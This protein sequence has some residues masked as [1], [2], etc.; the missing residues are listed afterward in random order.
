MQEPL[1]SLLGRTAE[2]SFAKEIS[3][4]TA[5]IPPEVDQYTTELLQELKK[6]ATPLITYVPTIT[7]ESFLDG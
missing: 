1:L 7:A 2:T 3:E 5:T 4:G 6:P